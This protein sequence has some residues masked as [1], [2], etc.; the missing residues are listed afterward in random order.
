MATRKQHCYCYQAVDSFWSWPPK[1][2]LDT[3]RAC[4]RIQDEPPRQVFVHG[5]LVSAPPEDCTGP[6]ALERRHSAWAKLTSIFLLHLLIIFT[7]PTDNSACRRPVE[8]VCLICQKILMIAPRIAAH[9]H[10]LRVTSS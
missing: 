3:H 10:M 6:L 4:G 9:K 1:T 7:R 2:K 8:F 5:N